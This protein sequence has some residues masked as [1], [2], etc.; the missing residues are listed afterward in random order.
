[1]TARAGP[2]RSRAGVIEVSEG[3]RGRTRQPWN[4]RVKGRRRRGDDAPSDTTGRDPVIGKESSPQPPCRKA[5]GSFSSG[6]GNPSETRGTG[7]P[8]LFRS[9]RNRS[10]TRGTARPPPGRPQ[11]HLNKPHIHHKAPHLNRAR[12]SPCLPSG[13]GVGGPY[14]PTAA[15]PRD[16]AWPYGALPVSRDHR[17]CLRVTG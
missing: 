6:A 7:R 2:G 15:R 17:G 13:G 9:R 1:M 4:R 8:P 16:G 10:E 14:A 11:P 12:H 3:D 5:R